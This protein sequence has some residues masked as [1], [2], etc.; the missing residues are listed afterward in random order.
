[1]TLAPADDP[2]ELR[3]VLLA[4]RYGSQQDQPVTV[5]VV[6]N[7]LTRDGTANFKGVRVAVTPLGD[8]PTMVWAEI[9]PASQ[10]D[11]GRE[12][13][14]LPW[15]GGSR[16]PLGTEQVVRVTWDGG[17]TKP[18]GEPVDDVERT[19]YAVATLRDDSSKVEIKSFALADLNDG[20]NKHL[21]C[22]DTQD[23]VQ[24]VSFPGLYLTDPRE[25]LNLAT[26]LS[27]L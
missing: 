26:T 4:G 22:L 17:I 18:S 27:L 19:L 5:K 14:T 1:M 3:T 11:L 9:A 20:D 15:G 10:W 23:A 25:A 21:L 16:C 13:T 12:A 2:G 7:V 8:G 24:S 6:G